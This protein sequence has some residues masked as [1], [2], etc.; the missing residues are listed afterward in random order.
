MF[1]VPA[2]PAPKVTKKILIN[3]FSKGIVFGDVNKPT[4]LVKTTK[5][6]TLGFISKISDFKKFTKLG[7]LMLLFI[8]LLE[9]IN[10]H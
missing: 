9:S 7:A 2:A 10:Q 6:M 8:T 3:A 4:A 1:S 5:D